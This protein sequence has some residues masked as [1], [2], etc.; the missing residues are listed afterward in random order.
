MFQVSIQNRY[1]LNKKARNIQKKALGESDRAVTI[2]QDSAKAEHQDNVAEYNR[3]IGKIVKYGQ[4]V[5][6]RHLFTGKYV[7]VSSTQGSVRDKNNMKVILSEHNAKHAQF[8]IHSRY[9]V[10]VEGDNVQYRDIVVFESV[11][12][13]GQFLHS[14]APWEIYPGFTGSELNLGIERTGFVLHKCYSP[15]PGENDLIRSGSM[16]RLFHREL[17]AYLMTD[18][19]FV[20]GSILTTDM[21]SVVE[22]ADMIGLADGVYL[23]LRPIEQLKNPKSLMPS[24]AANTY[25]QIEAASNI[26]SGRPIYWEQ[27]IRLRHVTTR[28]YL[29]VDDYFDVGL[30]KDDDDPRTVFRFTPVKTE[31]EKIKQGTFARIQHVV[32]GR[33]LH[34]L[35]AE[36]LSRKSSIDQRTKKKVTTN[37]SQQFDDAYALQ[38]VSD[39]DMRNC[40]FVAGHTTFIRQLTRW[41]NDQRFINTAST[42]K[43]VR[44]FNELEEFLVVDGH[45]VKE[46]QKLLRNFKTIDLLTNLLKYPFVKGPT[47]RAMSEIYQSVY[48]VFHAYL[49]GNSQKNALYMVPYIKTFFH[50]LSKLVIPAA[51]SN[52]WRQ[53]KE[54]AI[55][56]INQKKSGLKSITKTK[57]PKSTPTDSARITEK[58]S[59]MCLLGETIMKLLKDNMKLVENL[60]NDELDLI[61]VLTKNSKNAVFLDMM[62]AVCVCDGMA[63]PDNQ[64]YIAKHLFKDDYVNILNLRCGQELGLPYQPGDLYIRIQTQYEPLDQFCDKNSEKYKPEAMNYLLRQLD[65]IGKLAYGCNQ[66]VIDLVTNKLQL[67]TWNRTWTAI[68]R[69]TLPDDV[70]A[71]FCKLVI[72]LFVNTGLSTPETDHMALAFAYDEVTPEGLTRGYVDNAHQDLAYQFPEVK[73]FIFQYIRTNSKLIATNPSHNEFVGRIVELVQYLIEFGYFVEVEDIRNLIGP[74]L[75]TLDG[76]D[77]LP[78]FANQELD[79]NSGVEKDVQ[80]FRTEKRFQKSPNNDSI[81]RSKLQCMK[82]I[83]LLMKFQYQSLVLEFLSLFKDVE[84]RSHVEKDCCL[85]R[86]PRSVVTGT[87]YGRF[88]IDSASSVTKNARKKLVRLFTE[89]QYFDKEQLT[90]VL[91]DCAMYDYD[92]MVTE[93]TLLLSKFYSEKSE[94]FER[95]HRSQI[96]VTGESLHVHEQCK[97]LIP[98]MKHLARMKWTDAQTEKISNS[99]DTL[100]EFCH[101][102]DR[103]SMRH[104]IN[105]KILANHD[106]VAVIFDILAQHED[107]DLEDENGSDAH[108]EAINKTFRCLEYLATGNPLVQEQ[109][110][111]RLD[112][113]LTIYGATESMAKCLTMVF[114]NNEELCLKIPPQTIELLVRRAAE[115]R[116]NAP[117][118]LCL[119]QALT[120]LE[121]VDLAL[122]RN[123]TYMMK[124]I[125]QYFHKVA[126]V[127][128]QP[129]DIREQILTKRYGQAHLSYYI[130][131]VELIATCA[132]GESRFIESLGQKFVPTDHIFWVL[133]NEQVAKNLKIPFLQYLLNMYLVT[134]SSSM[135]SG[136]AADLSHDSGA[137]QH[138]ESCIDDI[139][140]LTNYAIK[141]RERV[142]PLIELPLDVSE[143]LEKSDD[144]DFR[145]TLVYVLFGILPYCE[146]FFRRLYDP[147]PTAYP[148]EVEIT[149]KIGHAVMTF[150]EAMGPLL[151]KPNHLRLI[152][153]ASLSIAPR[154][155]IPTSVLEDFLVKCSVNDASQMVES[156]DAV[157]MDFEN[158]YEQEEELN[159]QRSNF[160]QRFKEIYEGPNTVKRQLVFTNVPASVADKEYT[161][162]GGN[163]EL[164][165]GRDFQEFIQ[166]FR[167]S[168]NR[169]KKYPKAGILLK[170]LSISTK[171][172]EPKGDLKRRE[173]EEL[174]I[175]CFKILR[176]MIVNVERLLPEGYDES[177]RQTKKILRSLR[178]IQDEF[179]NL[180]AIRI[181]LPQVSRMNNI[182]VQEALAFMSAMLFNANKTT[183]E[184]VYDNFLATE[185]ET[186]FFALRRQIKM[187]SVQIRERRGLV[188]QRR[189]K[190]AERVAH[191]KTLESTLPAGRQA[192]LKIEQIERQRQQII[193]SRNKDASATKA[194]NETAAIPKRGAGVLVNGKTNPAFQSDEAGIELKNVKNSPVTVTPTETTDDGFSELY[195]GCDTGIGAVLQLLG[196]LCDGQN[197]DLQ[198]YLREQP[199]NVISCNLLAQVV[200]FTSEVYSNINPVTIELTSRI[201][202]TINEMV[203]GNHKNQMVALDNKIIDYVNYI[204][205]AKQFMSCSSEQSIELVS[206]VTGLVYS[207]IEENNPQTDRVTKE[208]VESLDK[209]ALLNLLTECYLLSKPKQ[210][211]NVTNVLSA[212]VDETPDDVYSAKNMVLSKGMEPDYI[213]GETKDCLHECGT[214]LYLLMR[215]IFDITPKFR[216]MYSF[217]VHPSERAA[218]AH[219]DAKN[220]SCEVVKDNILQKVNFLVDNT[221]ILREEVIERVKWEVD[222]TSGAAKIRDLMD[223]APE[224]MKDMKAQRK[225]LKSKLATF[226]M[227]NWKLWNNLTVGWCIMIQ[228]FLLV[229]WKAEATIN[230]VPDPNA[231]PLPPELYDTHTFY[232][233]MTKEQFM[234]ISYT[235]GAIQVYLVVIVV[236]TYFLLNQPRLP[237][238]SFLRK[239]YAKCFKKKKKSPR[240][241]QDGADD[242]FDDMEE[243]DYDEEEGIKN[244]PD[245]DDDTQGRLEAKLFS[246]TTFYFAIMLGCSIAG[247]IYLEYFFCAILLNIVNGNQLL[248]RVIKA[249]TQNGLSLMWVSILGLILIYIFALI[250]FATQRSVMDATQNWHCMTLAQCFVTITRYGLIGDLLD[251]MPIPDQEKYFARFSFYVVYKLAFFILIT[252][253]GLNIIFGIIVDTF[254]ELRDTK[255]TAEQDMRDTCFICGCASYVFE[256]NGK[257]FVYHVGKEHNM[258]AYMF[259]FLKLKETKVNDLNAIELYLRTKIE[260]KAYDFFPVERALCLQDAEVDE[261]EIQLNKMMDCVQSIFD[262]LSEEDRMKRIAEEREKQESW[263]KEQR[264][265]LYGNA[266]AGSVSPPPPPPLTPLAPSQQQHTITPEQVEIDEHQP[267]VE[268][269]EEVAAMFAAQDTGDVF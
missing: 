126:Y 169:D 181:V 100:K 37:D 123:Q 150:N 62:S 206:N 254:S 265:K 32:S 269:D 239:V 141:N 187:S 235:L 85:F 155:D 105:Q 199:D 5:Q 230:T 227:K 233:Y 161:R 110:Y 208:C 76:R 1:K 162:I 159:E 213:S 173:R 64:N 250:S 138:L 142:K 146:V 12:S 93:S 87:M 238:F 198:N 3:N 179:N 244:K 128:D 46:R 6:L 45:P 151:T 61:L 242:T 152:C 75:E 218:V 217:D 25:W 96:L 192:L 29:F 57:T 221:A 67:L 154:T 174:D 131:L 204:L 171:R 207:L 42:L 55:D 10:K 196:K 167:D 222:R 109:V 158:Y 249:V 240:V 35:A 24:T 41:F 21:S 66:Y 178:T 156:E 108:R 52:K 228:I 9:K 82:V 263:E 114:K 103:P 175:K 28:K 229:V 71:M 111:P 2:A 44:V 210:K 59:V 20:D 236:A 225:L 58:E 73:A 104:P 247:T 79:E 81:I 255:W 189:A 246:F 256:H 130:H 185:Q 139:V 118:M 132:E 231:N 147:Q 90:N 215:R 195:K 201:L 65:L 258:W 36:N 259:L 153:S 149:N 260:E 39:V 203:V 68:T 53:L 13:P 261:K 157:Y 106:L 14:S 177:R 31:I 186:F 49:T 30:S 51:E 226:L 202:D 209:G 74:I 180:D 102:A 122:K 183:Q 98:M 72:G 191:A 7:H 160:V 101:L 176:A 77:D 148:H 143:V 27:H 40:N 69:E 166:C 165:L 94:M 237:R 47:V 63:I 190:K 252:T 26:L 89:K 145:V 83:K 33:W 164:P 133:N 136:A 70:R 172:G 129:Q 22:K 220:I 219:Y 211:M 168:K 48:R 262:R 117:S 127:L 264:E 80:T 120:K 116:E 214:G 125:M 124:F 205:R 134:S 241:A 266:G 144:N 121:D 137:W 243:D 50:R 184:Q 224:I 19:L 91:L 253:I 257:G 56:I 135:S 107:Q 43:A 54:H 194:P 92:D 84:D 23:R 99:M 268:A 112:R 88:D 115:E 95:A 163:E 170:Q 245:D 11:K 17:E 86:D 182:I 200:E 4:V 119:L 97:A 140:Q 38:A 8:R 216:K 18:G 34:G 15:K 212:K 267:D 232:N 223:W 188:S 60:H 197:V 248:A 16:F 234:P 193:S 113:I 78:F 251:G